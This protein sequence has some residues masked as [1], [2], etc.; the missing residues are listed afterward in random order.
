M[1]NSDSATKVL[2]MI[3]DSNVTEIPSGCCGMAGSF[4][5][6]KEHFDISSKIANERLIPFLNNMNPEDYVVTT[7][8]SCRHQI[9]DFTDKQPLHFAE[10]LALSLKI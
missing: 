3:P 1:K 9:L 7:G 4:G 6:E 2:K 8:V 5:Y 10:I